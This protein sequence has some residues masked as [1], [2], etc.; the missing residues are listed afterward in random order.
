[1]LYIRISLFELFLDFFLIKVHL[2][3]FFP[4]LEC[5]VENVEQKTRK[6]GFHTATM[7]KMEFQ[8]FT[9][10]HFNTNMSQAMLE[11]YE[12]MFKNKE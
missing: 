10:R 12:N 4:H 1:M 8:S 11:Q 3:D 6:M 9:T 5:R 7:K 2:S